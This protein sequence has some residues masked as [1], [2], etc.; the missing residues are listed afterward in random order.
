[1]NISSLALRYLRIQKRRTI[2][3]VIGVALAVALVAGT[4][5]LIASFLHMRLAQATAE[6]GSW[7]YQVSGITDHSK[8]EQLKSNVLFQKAGL[9]ANDTVLLAGKKDGQSETVPLYEYDTAA[10][11]MMP[12]TV[13]QG[14]MPQSSGE[15]M[16]STTAKSRFP[17]VKLG[18]TVTLPCGTL[19]AN[20]AS[21]SSDG[22]TNTIFTA[23]N[24]GTFTQ[25]SSRT[26]T[27]VGFFRSGIY[28]YENIES[29][30]TLN[31]TGAHTYSVYAQIKPLLNFSKSIQKAVA[32]CGIRKENI[33]ENGIVEW[34]GKSAA[35][36]VKTAVIATFCILAIVIL[37]ITM[38]VIR[39]SFAMSVADKISEIGTLRCLGAAPGHIRNLVLSEAL[40]IWGIAAPVGLLLGTG[41][42]AIVIAAV[43]QLDPN[44]FTYL[45]LAPAA[46]PFLLAALLSLFTVLF[47]AFAPVREAMRV[48]MVEAVRGNAI[49]RENRIRRNRKGRLLGRILG[50]SGLLAAKN[51]RRNPKRF[52]TT[53]LSVVASVVLFIT[54][55]GFAISVGASLRTAMR[56]SRMADYTYTANV[57]AGTLPALN[58]LEK[59]VRGMTGIGAVQRTPIYSVELSVPLSRVPAGYLEIYREFI[60]TSADTS[61]SG[62]VKEQLQVLEVSRENYGSLRFSGNVPTYDELIQ[63]GGALLC[64][65][66]ALFSPSG[67]FANAAFA[68]YHTGE[69]LSVTQAVSLSSE[70]KKEIRQ[71]FQVKVSGI[72]SELPWFTQQ[73]YDDNVGSGVEGVLVFPEGEAA[74]FDTAELKKAALTADTGSSEPYLL[75]IHYANGAEAQADAKIRQLMLSARKSGVGFSD[76]YQNTVSERNFYLI[77]LI[78]VGGFS[79]VVILISCVNLFNTIHANMQTRKREIAMTRAVGMSQSQLRQMLLLECSLYGIIGTI[80][81]AVI[82]LPLQ[83]LLLE[84]FNMVIAANMAA[85]LLMA[86]IALAA[87]SG[88]GILAGLASIRRII[89]TPIVEEIRAQE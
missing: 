20:G 88:I 25:K 27:V 55:G 47:S 22:S 49:Y 8:A 34:M 71:T 59:E 5:L 32:D 30:V 74:R 21:G 45:T 46:W 3:T 82:G 33:H 4:G 63:S 73:T 50:F 76:N 83:Y 12:D 36:K 40:L 23:Q 80:W 89:K 84:K 86:L 75:A 64:E 35:T 37:F 19:T 41:A 42:M 11:S 57:E 79:I 78:F 60:G 16:I 43:R 10:L 65:T 48:P 58:E 29:A 26:F 51:I 2:L 54:V 39:N 67:R 13:T 69:T 87:T 14:R 56:Q 81:G 9:V 44:D 62:K 77:M 53:V 6:N 31:P 85:P 15:V 70:T 61:T 24:E 38:L 28:D 52:R 68:N 17:G 7:H 72:L 18:D 1:M 66:S